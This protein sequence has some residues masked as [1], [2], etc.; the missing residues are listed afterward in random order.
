MSN[1]RVSVIEENVNNYQKIENNVPNDI[2][3]MIQWYTVFLIWF[4]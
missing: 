3:D 4:L 2:R 1:K